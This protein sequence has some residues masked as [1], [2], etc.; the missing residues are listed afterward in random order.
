MLGEG[1][2]GFDMARKLLASGHN[3]PVIMMTGLPIDDPLHKQARAQFPVLRK[4][5]TSPHLAK[6]INE[7]RA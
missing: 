3:M 4:P 2:N 5:F 6:K 1:M 7:V